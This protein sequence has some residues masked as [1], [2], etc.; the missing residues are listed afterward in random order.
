MVPTWQGS[1]LNCRLKAVR[2]NVPDPA[3]AVN[4]H[5]QE[6]DRRWAMGGKAGTILFIVHWHANHDGAQTRCYPSGGGVDRHPVHPVQYVHCVHSVHPVRDIDRMFY[7][8]C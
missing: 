8:H 7:D 1:R 4:V 2:K 6:K 3:G 5:I